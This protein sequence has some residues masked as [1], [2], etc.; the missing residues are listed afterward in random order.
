VPLWGTFKPHNLNEDLANN[1]AVRWCS[2]MTRQHT[3][4]W[5]IH[6]NPIIYFLLNGGNNQLKPFK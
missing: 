4:S 5:A 2:G 3:Q 1:D 6:N